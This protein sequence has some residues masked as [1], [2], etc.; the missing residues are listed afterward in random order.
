MFIYYFKVFGEF[1]INYSDQI[2]VDGFSNAVSECRWM[3]PGTFDYDG[4]STL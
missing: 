2:D 1:R 4:N 3:V